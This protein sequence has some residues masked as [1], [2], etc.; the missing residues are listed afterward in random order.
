[1]TPRGM[2]AAARGHGKRVRT[3]FVMTA[4]AFGADLSDREAKR[5]IDG[6]PSSSTPL[7]EH[8]DKLSDL[9]QKHGWDL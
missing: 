2:E 5:I 8:G 4:R 6:E 1:M 3:E 9:A 7:D